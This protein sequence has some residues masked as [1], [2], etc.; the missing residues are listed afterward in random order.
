MAKSPSSS[1][2][3]NLRDSVLE[4]LHST[5]AFTVLGVSIW[6]GLGVFRQVLREGVNG[7]PDPASTV[8]S[9]LTLALFV[10][11]FVW[12]AN[13]TI[14]RNQVDRRSSIPRVFIVTAITLL[15]GSTSQ[16]IAERKFD[17][18]VGFEA[19]RLFPSMVMLY[20]VAYAL[21]FIA[22]YR[23]AI[24]RLQQEQV[25]ITNIRVEAAYS[26]GLLRGRVVRIAHDQTDSAAKV[27][28]GEMLALIAKSDV[29]AA[30][31]GALAE[32]IRDRLID[33]LRTLSYEVADLELPR[34]AKQNSVDPSGDTPTLRLGAIIRTTPIARPFWPL[35]LGA[36]FWI[37]GLT[38]IEYAPLR[39]VVAGSIVSA[40][41]VLLI[42]FP[43][44]RLLTGRIGRLSLWAQW[45]VC[46]S[47]YF[48]NAWII[49]TVLLHLYGWWDSDARAWRLTA[50]II[51][52]MIL[53]ICWGLIAAFAF[54]ARNS[55]AALNTAIMLVRREALTLAGE[56]S[57]ER[58]EIALTLHGEVQSMLT[59]AAFR[60]DLGRERMD[61][62]QQINP[63]L[64]LNALADAVTIIDAAFERIDSI[65]GPVVQQHAGTLTEL[66]ELRDAW[67]QIVDV[68]VHIDAATAARLD[69]RV[70]DASVG[71]IVVDIV[72]E[73]ILNAV[74]HAKAS[75]I[76]VHI[77]SAGGECRIIV[78]NDGILPRANPSSG[79]GQAMLDRHASVWRLQPAQPSG[80]V[81][82]VQV[83]YLTV[84]QML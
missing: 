46:L 31:L 52:M 21:E 68:S 36:T 78:R 15:L 79:L 22:R 67:T 12:L 70:N 20:V 10:V 66:D 59:T 27:I 40:G 18:G 1:T 8:I 82:H 48:V 38:N 62:D 41:V 29:A 4:T 61:Q 60:L 13:V 30:Q 84:A 25:A 6:L 9:A 33:P 35:V 39:E 17:A 69:E 74:R 81:L 53:S 50:F 73:A 23:T 32:A 7:Y 83:P 49:S 58:Q 45:A 71:P 11:P 26:L 77:E 64:G 24:V 42:M 51:G 43:A 54:L 16:I 5:R 55:E 19:G 37:S 72:Q 3:R 65:A 57:I 80:A 44:D 2:G 47:I 63:S 76:S 56:E 75:H 14:L 34:A 28:R